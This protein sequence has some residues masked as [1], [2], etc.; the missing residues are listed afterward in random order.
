LKLFLDMMPKIKSK[1]YELMT[2]HTEFFTQMLSTLYLLLTSKSKVYFNQSQEHV[3]RPSVFPFNFQT[4]SHYWNRYLSKNEKGRKATGNA[5][6]DNIFR[7][8]LSFK[9]LV[10]KS[11]QDEFLNM[12]TSIAN[13]ARSS[14]YRLRSEIYNLKD[15]HYEL[16]PRGRGIKSNIVKLKANLKDRLLYS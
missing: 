4:N 13:F 9:F 5:S 16:Y 11:A 2:K 8:P 12:L 1:N 6:M 10:Q 14:L 3:G 7:N 15:C